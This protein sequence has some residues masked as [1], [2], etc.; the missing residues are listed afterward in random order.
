[1]PR[2][3]VKNLTDFEK[4]DSNQ[5][6]INTNTEAFQARRAQQKNRVDTANEVQSMKK[7]IQPMILSIFLKKEKEAKKVLHQNKMTLPQIPKKSPKKKEK[8]KKKKGEK[9]SL[10]Y[11]PK[12]RK[13]QKRRKRGRKKIR[14]IQ[15]RKKLY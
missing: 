6:I 14:K 10:F 4:E 1:M 13:S 11:F 7:D 12:K 9:F 15:K 5:A 8:N 2:K 3:K